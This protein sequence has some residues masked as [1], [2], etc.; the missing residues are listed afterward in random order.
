[1]MRR[2]DEALDRGGE[3]FGS[4]EISRVIWLTDLTAIPVIRR[5]FKGSLTQMA[6]LD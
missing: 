1:M 4:P 3:P 2:A 6:E 5:Q